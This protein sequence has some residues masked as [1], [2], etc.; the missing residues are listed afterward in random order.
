MST[1]LAV[2]MMTATLSPGDAIGNYIMTLKRLLTE[3]GCR[4]QLYADHIAPQYRLQ[5]YPSA[6]YSPTGRDLLWYHYSIYADNLAL[7]ESSTDYR[8]MDFHG[9][10]PSHLFAGYDPHLER[11]CQLGNDVLPSFRDRFD[12]CIVH[13][14]Y[15]RQVLQDHGFARIEKLPLIVDTARYDGCQ[16]VALSAWLRRLTYLLFV[17]RIVPQKDVLALLN[18]FARL[19][20]R[21]PEV[22]LLLVGGRDLAP[23]YQREIDRA[24]ERLGLSQRV[25]FTGHITDPAM[26]ASLF[27]HAR[28]T[29]ITSEWESFCVPVVES[30]FFE[31]PVVIHH[32]PPLPEVA[33]DAGLVIDKHRLEAAA[34]L[35]DGTW[36]D[37]HAYEQLKQACRQRAPHFT[38]LALRTQLLTVLRQ[39]FV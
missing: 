37:G 10:S 31:T 12:L 7:V 15:S 1:P 33:G 23:V 27:R 39:A 3:F 14:E 26:L 22:A 9:V 8:I 30:M 16:D 17:G 34:E 32:V 19:R 18:L 2:H 20:S 11:L 38:T 21:R 36:A 24:V 5:A 28:F 6:G 29:V 35:I 13:S 25:L 4:V